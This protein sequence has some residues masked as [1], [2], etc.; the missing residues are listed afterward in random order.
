MQ[1]VYV[2]PESIRKPSGL[3]ITVRGFKGNPEC[4]EGQQEQVYLEIG[5]DDILRVYIWVGADPI[6]YEFDRED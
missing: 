4:V 2:V 3:G 6:I 1:D 5:D